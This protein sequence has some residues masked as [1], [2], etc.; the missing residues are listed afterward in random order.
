MSYTRRFK[1]HILPV[2]HK[3]TAR[4]TPKVYDYDG[5]RPQFTIVPAESCACEK[6]G[7]DPC[8]EC[9]KVVCPHGGD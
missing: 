6:H 4:R 7:L 3:S 9:S 2:D 8:P 1:E 5:H